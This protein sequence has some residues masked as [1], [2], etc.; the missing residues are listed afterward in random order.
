MSAFTTPQRLQL[1]SRRPPYAGVERLYRPSSGRETEPT[2]CIMKYVFALCIL[3]LS[4]LIQRTLR[5]F[6]V[7]VQ[8][9]DIANRLEDGFWMLIFSS[10]FGA[11]IVLAVKWVAVAVFPE[12]ASLPI[13][14][15]F[16]YSTW[17]TIGSVGIGVVLLLTA[18]AARW[19]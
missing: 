11:C 13:W 16:S 1:P 10:L 7:E 6:G 9:T 17:V 15:A 4:A 18:K 2:F 19:W 5:L 8:F 12:L 14:D 3:A